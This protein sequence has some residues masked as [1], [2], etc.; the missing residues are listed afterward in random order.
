MAP[1]VSLRRLV[2]GRLAF[3]AAA[4]AL[5]GAV[6]LSAQPSEARAMQPSV[7]ALV[8]ALQ[9]KDFQLLAPYLDDTFHAPNLPAPA[10][11]QILAQV[12]ASGARIPRAVAVESV[13]PEGENL[14]VTA[15]FEFEDGA[16]PIG[17]LLTPAAKFVE[18]P[19]F[20]VNLAPGMTPEAAAGAMGG[21]G[22]RVRSGT[23]PANGGMPAGPPPAP[24]RPQDAAPQDGLREE[25]LRMRETDQR[26][27]TQE[28]PSPE[29]M[30]AQAELDRANVRRLEEIVASQGWPGASRVGQDASVA[31][32]LV[33]QHAE[34]A[35][36]ERMLPLVRDAAAS[37]ELLPSMAAMLEDRVRMRR[38]EKQLYGTQLRE[39]PATGRAALWPVEDEA[40]VDARRAAVGLP[41]LAMY[42]RGFGI[43]YVP[44]AQ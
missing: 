43:D 30:R 44:P 11:R 31:A 12:V 28:N 1:P 22:M 18:I 7:D 10:A 20:R 34:Q 39:D 25:L 24:A 2:S 23:P 8:R 27:R 15:R 13:T 5:L 42:L 35:V 38:G 17:L 37:G 14:R 4:A 6:P 16:R 40:Q 33:L 21:G 26:H 36:Q 29:A 19:L 3:A 9:Q 41:P 32:F